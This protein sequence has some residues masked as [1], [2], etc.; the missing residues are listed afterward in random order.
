[1]VAGAIKYVSPSSHHLFVFQVLHTDDN[2]GILVGAF[3]EA[4]II[5]PMPGLYFL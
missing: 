2:V 4:S 5:A 1:M 3:P